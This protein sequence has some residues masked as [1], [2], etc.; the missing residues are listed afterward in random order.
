MLGYRGN[1][2]WLDLSD[3]VVHFTKPDDHRGYNA[4]MSILWSGTLKLGFPRIRGQSCG[5]LE[6]ML[7]FD[8][9]R[10]AVAERR[11]STLSVV[12]GLDVVEQGGSQLVP[13]RP[14]LAADE[15]DLE[16]GEEGLGDG[17]VPAVVF[18]AHADLD[19]F[20]GE[21]VA[22]EAAR[23]LPRFK[24]S[25]QRCLATPSIDA[26]AALRRESATRGFFAAGC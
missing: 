13:A 20:A 22:V 6:L 2:D 7:G 15:L 14:S 1:D 11:M 16:G 24:W 25:S 10:G 26:S 8:L 17:V 23:V 19:A 4:M 21:H 3:H 12:E 9:R 5:A 18:T